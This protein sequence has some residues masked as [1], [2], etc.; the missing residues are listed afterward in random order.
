MSAKINR[1]FLVEL[2]SSYIRKFWS[3]MGIKLFDLFKFF[4]FLVSKTFINGLKDSN[5]DD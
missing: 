3:K 4:T 2:D 5:I 1:V